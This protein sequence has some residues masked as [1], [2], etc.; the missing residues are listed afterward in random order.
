MKPIFLLLLFFISCHKKELFWKP[1]FHF[2]LLNIDTQ[3]VTQYFD[4]QTIPNNITTIV[5]NVF[6]PQCPPCEEEVPE[7]KK[8]YNSTLNESKNILFISL[9]ANLETLSSDKYT[10]FESH[11]PSIIDFAK[12]YQVIYPIYIANPIILKS[13]GVTGFP[14]TFI[15]K[16]K[17]NSNHFYLSKKIFSSVTSTLLKDKSL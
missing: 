2:P 5:L 9:G 16:R 14:E 15:L 7:L 3:A 12:Q 11:I 8:F 17:N 10:T 13:L 4:I 1:D 6:A